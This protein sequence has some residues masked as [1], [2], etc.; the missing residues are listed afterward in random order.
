MND[1]ETKMIFSAYIKISKIGVMIRSFF[2]LASQARVITNDP[3]VWLDGATN[4]NTYIPPFFRGNGLAQ[5]HSVST[6]KYVCKNI[7]LV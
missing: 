6:N 1:S 2:W 7:K 4:A 3:S 5:L